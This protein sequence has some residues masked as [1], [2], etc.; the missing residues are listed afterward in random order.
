MKFLTLIT[1]FFSF[2]I[3]ISSIIQAQEL[4]TA[5]IAYKEKKYNEAKLI[6]DTLVTQESHNTSAEVWFY[7]GKVYMDIAADIRGAYNQL[8]SM[9]LYKAYDSYKFAQ[10]YKPQAFADSATQN[11]KKL[12]PLALN[13]AGS[14][15]KQAYKITKEKGESAASL[16]STVLKQYGIALRA[17]ELAHVLQPA[18]TLGYSIALYS[19]W[20]IR[21]YDA[22]IRITQNLI[23]K[24]TDNPVKH[25][26]YEGL[27]TA[28]RDKLND[29][30]KTLLALE[31]ALR[32]FPQDVKFREARTALIVASQKS[33]AMIQ[34]ALEKAGLN[35]KSAEAHFELAKIY[36]QYG[37]LQ[38]A[39]T[40]YEKAIKLDPSNIQAMF[41]AGGICYNEGAK[42]QKQIN[43]MTFTEYQKQGKPLEIEV[44][45]AYQKALPYFEQLYALGFY[46]QDVLKS[47]TRIYKRLKMSEKLNALKAKLTDLNI[48]IPE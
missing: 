15:Y 40:N 9:A 39:L 13:T 17:A 16:D 22:Y 23:N 14:Y 45:S 26:L 1:S 37:K 32:D 20:L 18:D 4:A 10:L 42:K 19:A 31:M 3:G 27:I 12:H 35:P 2:I 41:Y 34:D 24:I 29:N 38:E 8:D 6:L 36:Q 7:R 33:E 47:M 30:D 21:D 25:K 5:K 28:C 43:A 44:D 46:N 48:K 11:L